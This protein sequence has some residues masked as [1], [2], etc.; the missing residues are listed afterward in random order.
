MERLLYKSIKDL[1]GIGEKR[2]EILISNGIETLMDLLE[3]FPKNYHDKSVITKIAHLTY[4]EVFT[5]CAKLKDSPQVSI[6]NGKPSAVLTVKDDSALMQVVFYN[7][8]YMKNNF[9]TNA[10]YLFTAKVVERNFKPTMENPEYELFKNA[11]HSIVPIYSTPKKIPL[12]LIRTLIERILR[13]ITNEMVDFLPSYITEENN[14]CSKEYALNNIHFP[15]DKA[16]FFAAKRRLVFEELFIMQLALSDEKK[17]KPTNIRFLNTNYSKL[18]LPF[19]LTKAQS[20]VLKEIFADFASLNAMNRLVQGDVGSGKTAIALIT[21]YIAIINGYQ[22]ALMAPTEV[23]AKQHYN[24]FTAYLEPLGISTAFISGSI[25]RKARQQVL[26]SVIKG[27]N[28][29]IIGTHALIE[30]AVIIPTLG[31]VITDEQH[32]FGVRQRANIANKGE[33]PHIMIMTA[34]PI[35]RTLA[36]VLYRDMDISVIDELP[37]GRKPI[38]TYSVGKSYRKRIYNLIKNQLAESRQAFVICPMIEEG[39]GEGNL[40]TVEN[41]SKNLKKVFAD[42]EVCELHGKMP[43]DQKQ[44]I[45]ERFVKGEINILI[46]TTVIEVGIN[47]PNATVMLIENAERFGLAQLHQLRG[48]VGRGGDKSYCILVTDSD[49]KVCKERIKAMTQTD[50][51]FKLSEIDL[52]LRG[53]GDFYGTRQH[54]LPEM[55]IANFYNDMTILKEVQ[56][57]LDKYP[58][59]Q[60]KADNPMLRQKLLK[61]LKNEN[62]LTL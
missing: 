20:L 12:K 45:M 28:Q 30:E 38:E 51:G 22:A 9:Q 8:T 10:F 37:P 4:G 40:E 58:P 41:Y 19:E 50:S 17:T 52:N 43:N 59:E 11:A 32:R 46:S 1:K 56:A 42:Y 53:P 44:Q 27:N 7:Q 16:S 3:C 49:S 57:V 25:T 36:L 33:N 18:Q 5:V 55:K 29:M 2:A 34:T 61:Y 15:K 6:I 62:N 60:L 39:D 48:R 35:P 24:T 54:G 23:L 26:E 13:L 31:L 21:C 47:V 14:L